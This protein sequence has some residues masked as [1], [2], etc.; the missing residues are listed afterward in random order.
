MTW[1]F[2]PSNCLPESASLAKDCEPGSLTWAERLAPSLTLNGKLTRPASF[3]LACK[4]AAWMQH[5]S[6]ATSPPLT[7][8]N[9]LGPWIASLRDSR[10]KTCLLQADALGSMASAAGCFLKSPALPVIA[11]RDTSFWRT[12]QASLLPPPPLWTKPKALLTNAQPPA[13]WENWPTSGGMRNGS[14]FQRQTLVPATAGRG[15]FAGHGEPWRTPK[16][17]DRSGR[18]T[19]SGGQA[20]LDVQA[21]RWT[22]PDVC[23]GARDMSKIDPEAQK[24]AN[25]KRT[26][27]LPTEAQNWPTPAAR[28]AKGENSLEHCTVTGGGEKAH[29][30]TEQLCVPLFAPG[31]ADP[32]WPRI[33][34]QWPHLAPA[35]AGES[36]SARLNPCFVE[37]LMGWPIFWTHINV[38]QTDDQKASAARSTNEWRMLLQ[39]RLSEWFDAPSLGLQQATG[40]GNH[41]PVL[42]RETSRGGNEAETSG[43]QYLQRTVHANP[44]KALGHLPE[45]GMQ[46]SQGSRGCREAMGQQTADG[47]MQLLPNGIHQKA[48]TPDNVRQ[49][50]REQVGMAEQAISNRPQRLKCCG[51]GVVAAQAAFALVGLVRRMNEVN[52]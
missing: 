23:S 4:K 48:T 7:H 22:T 45:T 27:G 46:S 10:A 30:S 17:S 5:L 3:R 14:L 16:A 36:G 8:T 31:P 38:D 26:T 21:N 1:I 29:G 35:L 19:N 44:H 42:P 40:S 28:D 25:T 13:S 2:I 18:Q 24:R 43:M 20:H 37:F 15:G 33:I 9:G 11:V 52:T 32:A 12:S 49:V 47:S 34:Q 41:V 50:V 51:N 6:G 39:M